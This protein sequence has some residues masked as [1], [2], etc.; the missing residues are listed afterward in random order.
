MKNLTIGQFREAVKAY[1][2]MEKTFTIEKKRD[3]YKLYAY[4]KLKLISIKKN[5]EQDKKKKKMAMKVF[6]DVKT[7]INSYIKKNHKKI[8]ETWQEHES[9]YTDNSVYNEVDEFYYVDL[10]R[11]YWYISYKK[12][13]IS[14]KTF[15]AY[16]D[17][18]Y[19]QWTNI[20]LASIIAKKQRYYYR[21]G[22]LL[23]DIKEHN[24]YADYIYKD[25]RFTCYSLVGQFR[26]KYGLDVI[27]WRTDG[28]LIKSAILDK[29][30]E[31]FSKNGYIYTYTKCKRIDDKHFWKNGEKVKLN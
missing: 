5:E 10:K 21:N 22:K 24:D 14:D 15:G 3:N 20:A 4:N 27:G 28:V 29:V 18:E 23:A 8:K 19:K 6:R 12:K 31:W 1:I 16:M 2:N 26:D 17:R 7:D 13:Y 11:A 25:I 30:T 9:R